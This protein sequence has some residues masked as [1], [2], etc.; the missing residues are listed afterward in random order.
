MN[1]FLKINSPWLSL[2]GIALIIVLLAFIFRPKSPHYQISPKEAL[3]LIDD[4]TVSVAISD[5][6]G[7]LLIDIRPAELYSQ[8]HPEGA[9][10]IPIRQLLD[11]ESLELFGNLS[12]KGKMAVLYGSDELQTTAPLFLLKQL[13]YNNLKLL[14]GGLTSASEFKAPEV[15]TTE[16][17]VIDTAA[18]H[19]KPE[20]T[21]T[22]TITSTK[23]RGETVIPV[24]KGAS[25]GGGC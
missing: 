12:E 1:R 16:V 19:S 18:I 13:G 20:L 5:I 24:R 10:N 4:E 7:K 11:Q 2:L 25:A 9:I 3:N 22:S 14:K 21:E 23:K 8:S 17:S 6:T 15:A